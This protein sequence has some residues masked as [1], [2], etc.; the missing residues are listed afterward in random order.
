MARYFMGESPMARFSQSRRQ[1]KGQ[2]RRREATPED[3]LAAG[4]PG[5]PTQSDVSPLMARVLERENLMHALK[6]VKHNH[7]APGI[8]G[9]TV[10]A[11]QGYLKAHWLALREQL[12]TGQYRP[13]PVR[14][15]E[16]PKPDGRKRLLGI[17]TVLDRFIQQAIAQVVQDEWE[18][19]FPLRDLD[20]WIRRP[21]LA[22]ER[23]YQWKQWGRAGYRQLRRRGVTVRE[24]W[25]ISK[26]AH[27]PWHISRMPVLTMA[28]SRR[29][30]LAMGLPGLAA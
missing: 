1:G 14:R 12:V 3:E 26:S 9:M 4:Y 16:I 11:L 17:P 2:G 6:Q 15:V 10:E 5:N 23:R 20:K 18:S 19:H 29:T 7:G 27:R 22:T 13:Q 24:A 8:D 28:L 25:N 30:F 21:H